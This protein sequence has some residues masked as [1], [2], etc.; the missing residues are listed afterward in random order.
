MT[1]E[2]KKIAVDFERR[3]IEVLRGILSSNEKIVVNN[4]S[5][6]MIESSVAMFIYKFFGENNIGVKQPDVRAIFLDPSDSMQL[7]IDLINPE[8]EELFTL[9]SFMEYCKL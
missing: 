5:K 3:L 8:T 9:E 2:Q 6:K 4:V 7:R 1:K